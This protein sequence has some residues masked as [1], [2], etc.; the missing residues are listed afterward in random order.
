MAEFDRLEESERAFW[1]ADWQLTRLECRDCGRPIEECSD[2]QRPFYPYRQICYATMERDAAQAA[3]DELHKEQ[4]YHDGTFTNWVAKRSVEFPY[5]ANEGVTIGVADS[6]LQP[7][8]DFRFD[9]NAA[10]APPS[11]KSIL[12]DHVVVDESGED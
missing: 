8:A 3:Y 10:P 9:L 7:W 5:A 2:P 4:Q 12:D 11:A 6:D 1:I